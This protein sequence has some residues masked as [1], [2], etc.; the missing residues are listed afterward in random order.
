MR[1][2]SRRQA[3]WRPDS[4]LGHAHKRVATPTERSAPRVPAR[5]AA[6]KTSLYAE[7]NVERVAQTGQSS[8]VL[9]AP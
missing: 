2:A 6:V 8:Q 5:R 3:D 9:A 4:G 1:P 7:A